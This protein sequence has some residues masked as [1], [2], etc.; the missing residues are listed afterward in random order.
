MKT[1]IAV[2]GISFNISA[3]VTK[4]STHF[5]GTQKS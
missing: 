3:K 2:N 4:E 1:T 5:P